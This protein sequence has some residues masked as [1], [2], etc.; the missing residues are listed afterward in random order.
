MLKIYCQDCGSPTTYS[1]VKPKFCSSC[2]KP[3]DKN[4]VINKAQPQKPTI[5]KPQNIKINKPSLNIEDNEDDIHE[6]DE[7][8]STA[9]IPNINKIDFEIADIKPSKIKMGDI[10]SNISEESLSS[11][12]EFKTAKTKK[13]KK[14]YKVKNQDFINQFKAEAGSLRPSRPNRNKSDG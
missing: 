6:D 7:E 4:I 5:T 1:D 12:A 3:F 2:G 9:S 11:T 8:E 13:S 10:I 14:P